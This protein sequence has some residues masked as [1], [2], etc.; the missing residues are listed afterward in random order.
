M[1]FILMLGEN[2]FDLGNG[3]DKAPFSLCDLAAWI[4]ALCPGGLIASFA[5]SRL[6]NSDF[7]ELVGLLSFAALGVVFGIVSLFGRTRRNVW[8]GLFGILANIGLLGVCFWLEL[9]KSHF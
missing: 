7:L 9:A 8:M 1:N 5:A 6:F 3:S 2:Q 4:S